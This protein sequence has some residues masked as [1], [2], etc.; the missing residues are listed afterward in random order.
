MLARV[1]VFGSHHC[2]FLNK[3]PNL[4]LVLPQP[5]S[6]FVALLYLPLLERVRYHDLTI[7]QVLASVIL[8]RVACVA[9][10]SFEF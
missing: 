6:F 7:Q 1:L 9:G 3:R 5:Y 8:E 4:L 10:F 2:L